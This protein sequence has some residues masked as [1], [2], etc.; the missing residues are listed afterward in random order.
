MYYICIGLKFIG[1]GEKRLLL[2]GKKLNWQAM[3]SIIEVWGI[4]GSTGVN[5]SLIEHKKHFT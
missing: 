2:E 3:I 4:F 5:Q 1:G